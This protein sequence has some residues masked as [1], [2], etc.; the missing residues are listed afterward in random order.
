MVAPA[1]PIYQAGTLS[2]NPLAVSAGLA[3]LRR[4]RQENPYSRLEDL[5][6]RL[7]SGIQGAIRERGIA[8][9][10]QRVGSMFTLFFTDRRVVDFASAKTCDTQIFN[11]FFHAMLSQGIYLPPSQFEAA[12]ISAAHSNADIDRTVEAAA[13]ALGKI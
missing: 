10:F 5:G 3:T 7:E 6:G 11:R 12:F 9:Q 13:Q 8:A 2:G 4:L 1:G